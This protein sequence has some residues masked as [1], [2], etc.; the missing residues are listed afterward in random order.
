MLDF[1]VLKQIVRGFDL[2][3]S[4]N[5]LQRVNLMIFS[6]EI[7]N[8]FDELIENP[9]L[10]LS[11]SG[12]SSIIYILEQFFNAQISLRS[13]SGILWLFSLEVKAIF[14]DLSH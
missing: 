1:W 5:G 2:A 4:L 11:R 10:S 14:E 8:R 9:A 13:L 6:F 7:L 3:S 12:H